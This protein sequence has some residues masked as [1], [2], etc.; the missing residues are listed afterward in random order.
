M[1]PSEN[2]YQLQSVPL[3]EKFS[4]LQH[5]DSQKPNELV[6]NQS[7]DYQ[8]ATHQYE[9]SEQG[10]EPIQFDNQ[11]ENVRAEIDPNNYQ[12]ASFNRE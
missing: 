3:L 2:P 5:L 8:C 9:V 7:Q 4:N 12:S 1:V 6:A 11:F 10:L